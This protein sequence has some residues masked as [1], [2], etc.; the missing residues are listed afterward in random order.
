[1]PNSADL[2]LNP[3]RKPDLSHNST[4]RRKPGP[5]PQLQ[6]ARAVTILLEEDLIEWGKSQPG[7]LS[8]LVRQMLRA[9]KTEAV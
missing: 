9:A 8:Q 1:M 4:P 5:T 6:K 7:G 3:S 2:Y